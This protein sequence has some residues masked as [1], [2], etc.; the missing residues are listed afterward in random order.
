MGWDPGQYLKFADHRLRP[1]IELS[2]RVPLNAPATI[3]DLG[4][5][6]GELTRMLAD[7]W[8]NARVTGVDRLG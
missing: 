7:R 5:G 6:T 8:A 4:C 1:G 2:A 3:V